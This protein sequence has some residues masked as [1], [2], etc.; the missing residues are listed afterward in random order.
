MITSAILAAGTVGALPASSDGS[1]F[2]PPSMDDFFPAP[3]AFQGTPFELNR[4]M[5]VRLIMA[6]ALV[7][8][9]AIGAA[10]ARVVPGRFQSALEL[11]LDFVRKNVAEEILGP[12]F[13]RRYAPV[14]TT[15]F[16]G[17]LFLNISG[18]IPGLQIASTGVVGMPLIFAIVSYIAFFY[19][20]VRANGIGRYLKGSLAPRGVP[21]FLYP[22]IVP[23]EFLSTFILRPLTLTVRLMANMISGHLL[24]ALCF[25]ATNALFVYASVSLKALGA[26][27][28]AAGVAFI[29][30]EAFVAALQAYIFTLLTAVYIDS[31]VRMH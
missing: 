8:V 22:L 30:F 7:L 6:C 12:D 5:M 28:L 19:A 1:G 4:V 24:L 10:R 31:S 17:V 3:F 20:G 13:G 16:L 23:I 25:V 26:I 14:L 18:V 29:V 21:G 27:T 2:E 9:F 15:I 11:V